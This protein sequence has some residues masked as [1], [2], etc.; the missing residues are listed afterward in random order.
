MSYKSASNPPPYIVGEVFLLAPQQWQQ[1]VLPSLIGLCS[2]AAYVSCHAL[3]P[4]LAESGT[5][6]QPVC[7]NCHILNTAKILDS[8]LCAQNEVEGG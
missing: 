7:G 3:S 2:Q 6:P 4:R 5:R 1:L 8:K